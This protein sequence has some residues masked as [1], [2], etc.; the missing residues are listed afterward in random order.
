MWLKSQNDCFQGKSIS[1]PLHACYRTKVRHSYERLTCGSK[2]LIFLLIC[3]ELSIKRP[4]I[5]NNIVLHLYHFLYPLVRGVNMHA[6][7]YITHTHTHR[8]HT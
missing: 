1:S 8:V 2:L 4:E 6:Y 3:I 7:T 5:E